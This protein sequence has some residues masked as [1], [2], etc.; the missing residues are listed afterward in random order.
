MRVGFY[1]GEIQP[2]NYGG[3]FTFQDSVLQQILKHEMNHEIFIL[4]KG[5]G[6]HF[7]DTKNIKFVKLE[8]NDSK[9]EKK[10]LFGL[11][12][13]KKSNV[14]KQ[15]PIQKAI[16]ENNIDLMYSLH[17]VREDFNI[18]YITTVWDLAHRKTPYFPEVSTVGWT[19][20]MRENNYGPLLPKASGIVIGNNEGKRQV[21]HYYNIEPELIH[22][23]PM[24]TPNYVYTTN[25]DNSILAKNNLE[26]GKYFFYPAQFWAHKNHIVLL[27]AIKKLKEQGKDFKLALTGSDQGNMDFIKRKISEMGLDNEVK[28]LGFVSR[29]QIVALYKNAYALTF[30]SYMGPDN[31]PPLEAFAL[32]CPVICAD[33]Y[34]MKEQ[35]KNGALFFNPKSEDDLIA[36][37]LE[38]DNQKENLLENG[39]KLAK[40]YSIENYV[41][42]IYQII[43]DFQP[44]IDCWR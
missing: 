6:H 7:V 21:A 36:K 34:G 12:K 28:L 19:F 10:G 11:K 18:P 32:N 29:E 30:A 23:N 3:G 38:L 41:N 15:T 42:K 13:K 2:P 5:E 22:T 1:F 33:T 14:I 26:K 35:L 43:D 9:K 37:I 40:E 20:E 17:I 8:N 25:E 31:I 27:K 44:I 4:Y 39:Y 24:P 16:A